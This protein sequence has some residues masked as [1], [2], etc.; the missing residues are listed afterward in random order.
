MTSPRPLCVGCFAL[1]MALAPVSASLGASPPPGQDQQ[2]ADRPRRGG[3]AERPGRG[4]PAAR[5]GRMRAAALAVD[6][7]SD[8]QKARI[9]KVF[10]AHV[11]QAGAPKQESQ[12]L[13][14]E[15]QRRRAREQLA[16][17]RREL[18]AVLDDRQKDSLREKLATALRPAPAE[19]G[20]GGARGGFGFGSGFGNPERVREAMKPLNLSAEQQKRVDALFAATRE[21][22]RQARESGELDKLREVMQGQEQK[23]KEI[24]SDEQEKQWEELRPRPGQRPEGQGGSQ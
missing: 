13:A 4:D 6:G 9:N 2:G 8:D 14:P 12:G 17:L 21:Q 15:E 3:G 16:D 10:A 11:E 20:P 5:L 18:D 22:I 7:L 1:C 24:L 19:I 23:L